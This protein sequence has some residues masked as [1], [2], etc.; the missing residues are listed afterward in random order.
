MQHAIEM[1]PLLAFRRR[2]VRD[3]FATQQQKGGDAA[4]CTWLAKL[5]RDADPQVQKSRFLWG[6]YK[7]EFWW[8]EAFEMARMSAPSRTCSPQRT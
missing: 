3:A 6:P 5:A 8:F 4:A 7:P 2:L 1:R